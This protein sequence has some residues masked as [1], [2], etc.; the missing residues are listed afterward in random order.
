MPIAL[1]ISDMPEP[2]SWSARLDAWFSLS[3]CGSAITYCSD[4][5]PVETDAAC[6]DGSAV[7]PSTPR[8]EAFKKFFRGLFCVE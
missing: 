5:D 8:R 1:G 7:T 6:D 3:Q 2:L 4:S